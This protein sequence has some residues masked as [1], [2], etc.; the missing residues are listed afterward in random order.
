MTRLHYPLRTFTEFSLFQIG[1]SVDFGQSKVITKNA[2]IVIIREHFIVTS[3]FR[4]TL[5]LTLQDSVLQ[6][7][8]DIKWNRTGIFDI[9]CFPWLILRFRK[10]HVTFNLRQTMTWSGILLD[11]QYYVWLS[12]D[13]KI[14]IKLCIQT[15]NIN[16]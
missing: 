14:N 4:Q 12:M 6:L 5:V 15:R 1:C 8:F 16:I 7:K 9:K 13:S 11:G 3:N 10:T 2:S